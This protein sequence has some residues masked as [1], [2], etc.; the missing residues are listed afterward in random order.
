MKNRWKLLFLFLLA[1]LA[2]FFHSQY[3]VSADQVLSW[4]PRNLYLAAVVLLCLFA[5]KSL[6]VFVPLSLM[7]HRTAILPGP[8][9]QIFS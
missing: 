9:Y 7:K 8:L 4:Q 6:L 5:V 2:L 3:H 1:A